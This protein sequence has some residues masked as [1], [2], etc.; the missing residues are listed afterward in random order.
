MKQRH[1]ITLSAIAALGLALLPGSA[2]SQQ[3]AATH[4]RYLIRAVLTTEG[5]KDLQKRGATAL[6]ASVAK[7]VEAVGCKQESWYFDYTESTAYAFQDCPDEISNAA[8]GAVSNAAGFARVTARPV[9]SAEDMD[10]ALAK[11][12]NARPPQQ[13]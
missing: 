7:F 11:V 2:V 6:R 8:L 9:L 4:H 10:K 3:A 5:M 12:G 1:I 13:Q